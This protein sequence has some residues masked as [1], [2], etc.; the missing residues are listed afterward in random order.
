MNEQNLTRYLRDILAFIRKY[1]Q[2]HIPRS[3][4]LAEIAE[5]MMC[6]KQ[7]A[8]NYVNKLME[9]GF[10]ERDGDRLVIPGETYTLTLP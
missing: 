4:S 3:P 5:E 9:L 6:S 1:K 2:E 7:S 10:L 8:A